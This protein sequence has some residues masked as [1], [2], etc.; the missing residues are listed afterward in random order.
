MRK[1][2]HPTEH[3][4]F[5][6]VATTHPRELV[7]IPRQSRD[8]ADTFVY[9][10]THADERILGNLCFA[11]NIEDAQE[12]E[13][14]LLAALALEARHGYYRDPLRIPEK[15]FLSALRRLNRYIADRIE[16]DA[17][18]LTANRFHIAMAAVAEG[19][20]FLAETGS[21]FS[22]LLRQGDVTPIGRGVEYPQ[23][24]SQ[25][26][27]THLVR[28]TLDPEDLVLIATPHFVE[29]FL[30]RETRAT[31]EQ[32]LGELSRKLREH[33]APLRL[34]LLAE[35]QRLPL[36]LGI[37]DVA[38]TIFPKYVVSVTNR[39]ADVIHHCQEQVQALES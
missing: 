12:R 35:P 6:D 17:L 37:D 2:P 10:P 23:N 4:F 31:R 39:V 9:E 30:F 13:R 20:L 29:E 3:P 28:G 15:N 16:Q 18:L 1:R 8:I 5:K 24:L 22:Y 14:N 26:A 32:F 25:K 7:Y 38:H 21:A 11:G 33:L 36:L 34:E 19:T 27:F